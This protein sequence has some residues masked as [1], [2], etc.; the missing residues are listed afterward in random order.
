MNPLHIFVAEDNDDHAEMIIEALEDYNQNNNII[1]FR[2]GE[3]LITHILK[4]SALNNAKPHMPD[5]VLMDIKMPVMDGLEALKI[6][7]GNSDL[8]HIPV[9]MVST[10]DNSLDIEKSYSYGANSYIVKPFDY[11]EFAKKICEV[12]HFWADISKLLKK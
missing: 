1:H 11:K 10:S 2:N 6:I 12:N 3:R 7:K 4:I 9:M 8:R 5:L